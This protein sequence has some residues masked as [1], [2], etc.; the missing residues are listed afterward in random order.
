[1]QTAARIL[2]VDDIEANR[3]LV[4][5][6]LE[7]EGF[8]VILA[9]SGEQGVASFADGG[10]DCVILDV[11]MPGMNGFATCEKIRALPGGADVPVIFLTAMRD[12]DTFDRAQLAG[13]DDFLT[14]PCRPAELIARVQAALKLRKLGAERSELFELVRKQRDELMRLQLQKE[15]LMAFVVHDLKNPVN[16]LDLHAQLMQRDARLPDELRESA[17]Q[18]RVAARRLNSLIMNL[19]DLAKAEEGTLHPR[20]APV[21]LRALLEE[22]L[23]ELRV[24]AE[25]RGVKLVLS[26][27]G[28]AIRADEELV[29][30][31][32]ANL[33]ENAVRHAPK[34]SEVRVTLAADESAVETRVADAGP[35]IPPDMREKVFDRF[36]QV[37]AGE[38]FSRGGHG[39]GLTFCKAVADAHGGRVWVEDASPGAVLCLRLPRG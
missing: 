3:L 27:D 9:E 25:K 1:M 24:R 31:A 7:G 38:G 11:N 13:A 14:K 30:R 6:T 32:L 19:L 10:A 22:I 23:G 36:V 35:G 8:D 5:A 37:D 2:V 16:A 12:L 33:V 4:Q 26:G 21:E 34:D 17:S 39:L 18:I 15:R 29:R 20:L 28:A